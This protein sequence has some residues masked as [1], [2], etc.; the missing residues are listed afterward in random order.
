M[1]VNFEHQTPEARVRARMFSASGKV[2]RQVL[3]NVRH[4]NMKRQ[5]QMQP[6]VA[7]CLDETSTQAYVHNMIVKT[8]LRGKTINFGVFFKRHCRLR[9]NPTIS[10]APVQGDVIVMRMGKGY[11]TYVNLRGCNEER[12]IDRV[13]KKSVC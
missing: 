2:A 8:K 11:E 13:I 6:L 9:R 7:E 3:V 1:A 12:L 5:C 4:L 10:K